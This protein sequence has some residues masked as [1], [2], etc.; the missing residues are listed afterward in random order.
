MWLNWFTSQPFD[1]VKTTLKWQWKLVVDKLIKE[2]QK[3]LKKRR[4]FS[5]LGFWNCTVTK[6]IRMDQL[7]HTSHCQKYFDKKD[8]LI[9]NYQSICILS[10]I[11]L[12]HLNICLTLY[13]LRYVWITDTLI[14][15]IY[16]GPKILYSGNSFVKIFQKDN[17]KSSQLI[18]FS[19]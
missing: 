11:S 6:L 5:S 18:L 8:Y 17:Q 14:S 16:P 10:L 7:L 2:F 4:V 1:K 3:T 19:R 12:I 9:C 13:T 15:K